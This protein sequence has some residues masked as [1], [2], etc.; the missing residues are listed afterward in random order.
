VDILKR[1]TAQKL[2]KQ[3][4]Y[5]IFLLPAAVLVLIFNYMPMAG[6]IMAFQNFRVVDGFFG[7]SFVGF[8]NF[9]KFFSDPDFYRALK[10]T[11]GISG[12][13]IL[14]GFPAPIL[15][16]ILID[17][18]GKTFFKRIFQTISYLPHFV[19]WVIVA[20]LVYRM[21]DFESGIVNYMLQTFGFE[22]VAFMRNAD[23]FW[24]ILIFTVIWKSIGWNSIIYLAAISG[25]DPQLYDA[26]MVDG[27]GKLRRIRHITIP[28]ITPTIAL[29]FV[30][31]LGTLFT[32]NFDAVFNLMN[33]MVHAKAEVIDTY[34][35]RTGIQ[36]A[37]Y[38]Y[39]TSIGFM[40][41]TISL[42]IVVVGFKIAKKINNYS[43][44]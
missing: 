17:D 15:L 19:S 24:T 3:K 32:V 12:L 37:R 16:A 43:I 10:N 31:S 21:L 26:A 23:Y 22:Q 41:S 29:M 44:I 28:G 30:L 18:V 2:K 4:M 7:S 11:I 9:K 35:Y 33:P 39:A 42:I 8:E 25:I 40:Q 36:M 5:F 13:T 27:A 38:S 34:L 1:I 20:T 14:I 6:L